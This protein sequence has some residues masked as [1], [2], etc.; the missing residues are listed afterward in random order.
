MVFEEIDDGVG[1]DGVEA[2]VRHHADALLTTTQTEAAGQLD[3]VA[4]I[5]LA[6]E[7]LQLLYNLTGTLDVTG[8]AD[9]YRNFHIDSS[10]F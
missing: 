1:G 4:Q 5:I 7:V 3:L 9:T 8:T 10:V 2:V 6:D